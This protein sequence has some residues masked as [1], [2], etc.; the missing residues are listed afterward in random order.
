MMPHE[1][2][3]VVTPGPTRAP[4]FA[5]TIAALAARLA[6]P[7]FPTGDHAALRRMD[8]QHP[9]AAALPLFHALDRAGLEDGDAPATVRRWAL[10]VHCLALARGR[11]DWHAPTGKMLF[12]I[13]LSEARLDQLLAADL[14]VLFDLLPRIARR[15][16]A[17]GGAIDWVP[18]ARIVRWAG[19]HEDSAEEARLTIARSFAR[20][21]GAKA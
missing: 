20:A 7:H 3:P 12:E 2:L 4:G 19:L 17:Q 10:I 11:H 5:K 21:Q 9:G 14:D 1:D 6:D 16:A 18:L 15:L 13:G 8:P